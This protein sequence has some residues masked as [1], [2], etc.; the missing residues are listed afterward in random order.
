LERLM[1]KSIRQITQSKLLRSR[2]IVHSDW[3]FQIVKIMRA[4]GLQ[5]VWVV[6]L[7]RFIKGSGNR[8]VVTITFRQHSIN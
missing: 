1:V 6:E 5:S 2:D 3:S 8:A 7:I 4:Q